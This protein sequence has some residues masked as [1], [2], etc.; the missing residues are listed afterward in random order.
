M[1]TVVVPVHCRSMNMQP[2]I[3][4]T[5]YRHCFK[6]LSII[7]NATKVFLWFLAHKKYNLPIE[8]ILK[9]GHACYKRKITPAFVAELSK[10]AAT[11][12]VP[13]GSVK[14]VLLASNSWQHL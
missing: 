13:I 6:F 1:Y 5:S 11:I 7:K 12:H 10:V 4:S 2:S 3:H 9:N 8:R 14:R